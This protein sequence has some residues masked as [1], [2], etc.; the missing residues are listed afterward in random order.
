MI[1]SVYASIALIYSEHIETFKALD[2][3]LKPYFPSGFR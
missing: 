2:L 3:I 1:W